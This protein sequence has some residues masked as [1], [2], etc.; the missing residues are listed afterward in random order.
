MKKK[1]MTASLVTLAIGVLIVLVS[2]VI[3]NNRTLDEP[4][5]TRLTQGTQTR[6]EDISIGLSSIENDTAWLSV[7]DNVTS[8]S[9]TKQAKAD[10]TIEAYG[11]QIVVDSIKKSSNSSI[12]PG[13]SQDYIKLRVNKK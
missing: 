9:T 8:E 11:Y 1:R 4:G 5:T 13:S 7:R 10:E 2:Y 6:Y 12:L 3:L